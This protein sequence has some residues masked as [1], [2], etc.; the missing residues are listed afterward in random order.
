MGAD[1]YEVVI[2]HAKTGQQTKRE[3]SAAELMAGV[4]WLKRLNARGGDILV[5]PLGGP[6]LFLIASLDADGLNK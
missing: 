4:Q 2:T 3:W 1:R 5:G 6:Q